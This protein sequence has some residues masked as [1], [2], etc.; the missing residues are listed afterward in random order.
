MFYGW[1]NTAAARVLRRAALGGLSR[2]SGLPLKA[3]IRS[4]LDDVRFGP[5]A[6]ISLL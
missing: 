5:E 4:A 1:E 3:D 2:M 6:D